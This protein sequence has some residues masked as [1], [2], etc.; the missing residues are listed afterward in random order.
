MFGRLVLESGVSADPESIQRHGDH[1]VVAAEPGDLYGGFVADET[2]ESLEG[3]LIGVV[4]AMKLLAVVI[5]L[6]LLQPR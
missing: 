3:R 1:R 4:S 5:K 2:Q 6:L